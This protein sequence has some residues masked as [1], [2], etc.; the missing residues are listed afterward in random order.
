MILW[1]VSAW[2]GTIEVPGQAANLA[3]AIAMAVDGDEI[4]V[5][6]GT[7]QGLPAAIDVEVTV[8]GQGRSATFLE[9]ATLGVS[10]PMRITA[11][12][13]FE[14]LVIDG[15]G[16]STLIQ[17]VGVPLTL[18]GVQL[19]AVNELLGAA[20]EL[21]GPARLVAT[22]VVF[23][24]LK[25]AQGAISTSL[26]A[27]VELRECSFSSNESTLLGSGGGAL[28]LAGTGPSLVADTVFLANH[29]LGRGGAIQL[30]A[31]AQLEVTGSRFQDNQGD[32][33]GGAIA[34]I[35]GL[36]T[37]TDVI[38]TSNETR[39]EGDGG[40]LD[41][42]EAD[43]ELVRP[44]FCA[45]QAVGTQAAGGAIY[46]QGGT[47]D[48]YNGTFVSNASDDEGA[49]RV[50]DGE[51][52]LDHATF[53]Q[54]VS[55]RGSALHLDATDPGDTVTLRNSVIADN[56]AETPAQAAVQAG[57]VRPIAVQTTAFWNNQDLDTLGAISFVDPT[58]APLGAAP[59]GA[60]GE[61]CPTGPLLPISDEILD[62]GTD[63]DPDG[64][65]ADLGASGGPLA[66]PRL[67]RD[68]DEDG[69]VAWQDPDDD[70]GD[71]QTATGT[72]PTPPGWRPPEAREEMPLIVG[73][74]CQTQGR[75]GL[76]GGLV[77]L[78][79]LGV[80]RGCTTSHGRVVRRR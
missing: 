35:G 54:N 17:V 4:V 47:L 41:L 59:L 55:K 10:E 26:T 27:A 77:L 67:W 44:M 76:A 46:A 18:R 13:T 56:V 31:G 23:Q 15:L 38:F 1:A 8:R 49:V 74:G 36:L 3:E 66:D 69:E 22:D 51:A 58:I 79:A 14:D 21:T 40:A 28:H 71:C 11:A 70:E 60:V 19:I 5:S 37:A 73:C 68:C 63:D 72:T 78:V 64:S 29:A 9:R 62:Q 20:V 45:N 61:G 24:G 33:G 65:V 52:L 80:A 25:G 32:E 50:R 2:A 75:G 39:G 7:F 12:V 48:V 43:A 53:V 34:V 42:E 30:L 16:R 57:Q 6:A